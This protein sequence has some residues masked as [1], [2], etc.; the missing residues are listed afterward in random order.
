MKYLLHVALSHWL[1]ASNPANFFIN[2]SLYKNT[3]Q[4][5]KNRSKN[6]KKKEEK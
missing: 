4:R 3:N 6:T 2:L 5:G 1:R